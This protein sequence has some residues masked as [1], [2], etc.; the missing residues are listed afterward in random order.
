MYAEKKK[1]NGILQMQY[2]FSCIE[3]ILLLIDL[4]LKN[5]V[6]TDLMLCTEIP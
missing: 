3:T 6:W 1:W 5:I 4:F 2:F